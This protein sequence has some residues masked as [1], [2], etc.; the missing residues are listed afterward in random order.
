MEFRDH[1]RTTGSA[2]KNWFIA[3]S[4]DSLIVAAIW[5]AGLMIIGVP[6]AWLWA[7]LAGAFQFV[8]HIGP[9]LSL[10]GPIASLLGAA[11][12]VDQG[13]EFM[14]MVFVLILYAVVA[15]VDGLALQPYI[16]KRTVRVPIWAS[17]LTPII[18][19]LI[20]NLWGV[21]ASAPLLAIYYTYR[22][23]RRQPQVV[24]PDT[25][26]QLRR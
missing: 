23:R 10:L 4:C 8:P 15:V 9:V 12:F 14:K 17:I 6:L 11:I 24:P 16:M 26:P 18:L 22:T 7:L 1:V 25:R 19:G 2:L 5:L 13:G 20:F 3:Q 21:L